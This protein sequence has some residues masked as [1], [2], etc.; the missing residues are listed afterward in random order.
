MFIVA[1]KLIRL[2]GSIRLSKVFIETVIKKY[3]L[4]KNDRLVIN[5][6]NGF[7]SRNLNTEFGGIIIYSHPIL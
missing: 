7:F 6:L 5:F 2:F 1:R 4:S 3:I